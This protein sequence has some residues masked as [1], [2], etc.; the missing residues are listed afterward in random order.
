MIKVLAVF[1][2]RDGSL[3]YE[4]GKRYLLRFSVFTSITK[5]KGQIEICEEVSRERYCLY[6]SLSSFL[7]NW[8]IIK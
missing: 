6:E 3:G 1:K 8:D 2:G 5:N 7:K 4:L